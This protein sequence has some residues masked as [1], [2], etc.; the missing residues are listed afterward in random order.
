[1]IRFLRGVL[2]AVSLALLG[3][4]VP[5]GLWHYVGWPLPHHI[6]TWAEAGAVLR[7]PMST[8]FLLNTLA[9]V[10]WTVWCAFGVDVVRTART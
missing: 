9:C 6:P 2:A 3:T 10:L 8:T 1:M 7:A 4:G 5:W